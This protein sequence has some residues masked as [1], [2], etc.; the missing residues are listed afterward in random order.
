[1]RVCVCV[2]E[3]K[4]HEPKEKR[5]KLDLDHYFYPLAKKLTDDIDPPGCLLKKRPF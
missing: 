5:R 2:Q 3:T 4:L 1:M